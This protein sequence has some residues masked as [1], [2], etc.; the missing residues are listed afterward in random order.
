MTIS[1]TQILG[2]AATTL[3]SFV[4]NGVTYSLNHPDM[5]AKARLERLIVDYEK[6]S[7][8]DMFREGFIT[9]TEKFES[10]KQLAQRIR[11]GDHTPGGSIFMAYMQTGGQQRLTGLA[12]FHLSLLTVKTEG[13]PDRF[14]TVTD[15]TTAKEMFTDPAL[16]PLFAEIVPDFFAQTLGAKTKAP[17]ELVT[18]LMDKMKQFYTEV[19][20]K[21]SSIN[22]PS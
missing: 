14:A 1:V 15:L 6:Q 18:Q 13:K 11:E 12:L 17:P 20:T 7:I 3:P 21:L 8:E 10:Y 5:A 22:V 2:N 16:M 4:F 19:T 9:D